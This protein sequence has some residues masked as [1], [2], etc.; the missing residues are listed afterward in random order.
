[1]A[2][3]G[4]RSLGARTWKREATSRKVTLDP[5]TARE[6][7]VARLVASGASNPEIARA[8]FLS[9]KTV[10]RHVSNVLAK[11]GIRNRTELAARVGP[12][13]P[14]SQEDGR[15]APGSQNDGRTVQSG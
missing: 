10:E 2:E 8:L 11:L 4:L 14:G 15:T 1:M 5:L 7:E 12:V 13:D 9:R 6:E 3:Q